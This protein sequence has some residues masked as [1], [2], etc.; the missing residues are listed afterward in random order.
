MKEK[1]RFNCIVTSGQIGNF[2]AFDSFLT[3]KE[4][5]ELKK[6]IITPNINLFK[7]KLKFKE[8]SENYQ[9]LNLV[10]NNKFYAKNII[11]EYVNNLENIKKSILGYKKIIIT[12]FFNN[13]YLNKWHLNKNINIKNSSFI[14]IENANINKFNL[15]KNYCT[16]VGWSK[17]EEKKFTS[18]DW[19]ELIKILK[20]KNIKGVL[21]NSFY[22]K[23]V[24]IP[25]SDFLIDLT[26]KTSLL[27]SIEITK[28]ANFY[29]GINGCLSIIAMQK[30]P[31]RC[32]IKTCLPKKFKWYRIYYPKIK[33]KK[34]TIFKNINAKKKNNII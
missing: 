23:D 18:Y 32:I 1:K 13:Y 19:Q 3:N 29:I 12:E 25:K 7:N 9:I 30:Y 5:K 17:R 31:D 21:L 2:L 27:E 4:K 14:K 33:D 20:I 34:I 6:I 10:E 16:I 22:R 28:N 15:P 8:E 26:E 24:E 11:V